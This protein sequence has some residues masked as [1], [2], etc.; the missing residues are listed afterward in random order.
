MA[1]FADPTDLNQLNPDEEIQRNMRL[2]SRLATP[3][4]DTGARGPLIPAPNL[5]AGVNLPPVGQPPITSRPPTVSPIDRDRQR[6]D[7]LETGPQSGIEALHPKSTLG[8][9]GKLGLRGLD[10][11]GSI[12]APGAM[13]CSIAAPGAMRFIPGTTMHHGLLEAQAE[14]RMGQDVA[15]EQKEAQATE[16][17]PGRRGAGKSAQL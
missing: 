4:Q 12:A 10:V 11:I 13:R 17:S 5:S 1:P 16:E 6:L 9:I 15:Q 2:G 7:Q 8:K 14:R 3:Q